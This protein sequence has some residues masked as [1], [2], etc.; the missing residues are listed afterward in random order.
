MSLTPTKCL[1]VSNASD[2]HLKESSMLRHTF[3]GTTTC[4]GA[5]ARRLSMVVG[6]VDIETHAE[7][8]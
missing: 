4:P 1:H 3:S 8:T 6:C 2:A 7:V 5:G